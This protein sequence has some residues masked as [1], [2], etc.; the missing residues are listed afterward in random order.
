M[1]NAATMP[2][3]HHPEDVAA[4]ISRSSPSPLGTAVAIKVE[5]MPIKNAEGDAK[6]KSDGKKRSKTR[7]RRQR[8]EEGGGRAVCKE[9]RLKKIGGGGGGGDGEDRIATVAV[10]VNVDGD[11]GVEA[12]LDALHSQRQRRRRQRQQQHQQGGDTAVRLNENAVFDHPESGGRDNGIH[13]RK[14]RS[15]GF[16][17]SLAAIESSDNSHEV[18]SFGL[19]AQGGARWGEHAHQETETAGAGSDL[20]SGRRPSPFAFDQRPAAVNDP[21]S[22]KMTAGGDRR[23]APRESGEGRDTTPRSAVHPDDITPKMARAVDPDPRW[24]GSQL[25]LARATRQV[26]ARG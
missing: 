5:E 22:R 11:N 17:G 19:T 4:G 21:V 6:T 10:A 25:Q 26:A 7:R 13:M 8:Q 24:N 23:G 1:G 14:S 15:D 3:I 16:V 12:E 18:A 9:Q 2:M 20:L